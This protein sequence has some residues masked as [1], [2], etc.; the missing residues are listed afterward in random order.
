MDEVIRLV[1][2]LLS[3]YQ[4]EGKPLHVL[5]EGVRLDGDWWYVPVYP[6]CPIDQQWRYYEFLADVEERLE[7]ENGLTVL[8][9][10]VAAGVP[11]A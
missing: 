10:P 2:E 8:L 6:D 3:Q 9:V 4:G 7:S 5:R 11:T 1:S